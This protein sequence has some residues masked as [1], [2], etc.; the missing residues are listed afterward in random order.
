MIFYPQNVSFQHTLK[1]ANNCSIDLDVEADVCINTQTAE[2]FAVVTATGK[3]AR[4]RRSHRVALER[5]AIGYAVD[6]AGAA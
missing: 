4:L 3:V 2:V 5:L 1:L 6:M